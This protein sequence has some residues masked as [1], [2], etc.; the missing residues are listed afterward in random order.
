M[1]GVMRFCKKGK[2]S[3]LYVG[4]YEVLVRV[5]K[6]AYKLRLPSELA[7]VHPVFHISMLKKCIDD[8]E[9]IIPIEGIGVDEDHS[10]K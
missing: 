9:S 7:F 10:Y 5:R 6:V 1:K 8:H 2:L 3:P 4:H